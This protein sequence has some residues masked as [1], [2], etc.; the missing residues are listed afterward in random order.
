MANK[1]L[2]N[3]Y[4]LARRAKISRDW[5]TAARYYQDILYENP[6][7]WEA[8]FYVG[9]NDATSCSL[10]QFKTATTRLH[11]AFSDAIRLLDTDNEATAISAIKEMSSYTLTTLSN[12]QLTALQHYSQF[13]TLSN[14]KSEYNS[15]RMDLSGCA[16]LCGMSID[17]IYG[18]RNLQE[19]CVD[20][21]LYAIELQCEILDGFPISSIS[22]MRTL[23]DGYVSVVQKYRPEYKNPV[24]EALKK[25]NTTSTST[26]SSSGGCYVATAVY[27]SYDCPEVWTLRRYRDYT[28]AETWYGRAFIKTYYAIS[29]TLVKWFGHT[30][31]F[32]KMWKGK[33]DHMVENLNS[34][35][36]E[37]TPYEDKEW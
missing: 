34:K 37:D 36:F 5:A 9:L 23:V 2:D 28:L 4:E 19:L 31:W 27:G 10:A 25:V 29:P 12:F 14:S 30:E 18:K 3:K 32:K 20:L 17:S 24:T 8:T 22:S 13:A 21:Y 35:G 1:A 11:N 6:K 7:D 26:T 33:L 15:R 16:G